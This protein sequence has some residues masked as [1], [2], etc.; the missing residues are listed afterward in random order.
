MKVFGEDD[1]LKAHH[2]LKETDLECAELKS[3]VAY[4][5][6]MRKIKRAELFLQYEGSVAIR[7]ANA[8]AHPEYAQMVIALQVGTAEFEAMRNRRFTAQ[9]QIA[10][11]QTFSANSRSA[12][13]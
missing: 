3:Q 5:D 10:L 2:F 4:L 7:E 12:N 13:V 11:F 6:E 1:A 9:E 8:L